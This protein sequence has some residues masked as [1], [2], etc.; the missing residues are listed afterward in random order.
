[1]LIIVTFIGSILFNCLSGISVL[2]HV[3]ISFFFLLIS[4]GFAF[5]IFTACIHTYIHKLYLSSN[6]R[7]A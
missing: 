4:L 3:R 2:V 6:F 7:V 1:L 5:I